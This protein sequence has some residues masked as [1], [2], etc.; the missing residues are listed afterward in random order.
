MVDTHTAES[1]TGNFVNA[2]KGIAPGIPPMVWPYAMGTNTTFSGAID[3]NAATL[4]FEGDTVDG[5]RPFVFEI[6]ANRQ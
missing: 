1:M 5:T 6:V 4:R 3:A 2:A